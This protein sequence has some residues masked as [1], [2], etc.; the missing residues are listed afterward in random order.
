MAYTND[1]AA[2]AVKYHMIWVC[3]ACS[4]NGIDARKIKNEK[5]IPL[6]PEVLVEENGIV[7][8]CRMD[9]HLFRFDDES[10]H[11]HRRRED[12]GYEGGWG[13]ITE[14]HCWELVRL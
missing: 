13:D 2:W 7:I 1:P 3:S 4:D 12:C 8:G 14:T 11:Q 6:T 10:T 5:T 9:G